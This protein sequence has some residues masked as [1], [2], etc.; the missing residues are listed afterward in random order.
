LFA[1]LENSADQDL[2]DTNLCTT[3]FS[4]TVVEP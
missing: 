3:G 2:D 4:Y 1:C